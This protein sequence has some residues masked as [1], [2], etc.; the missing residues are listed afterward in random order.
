VYL[1]LE[2]WYF[3]GGPDGTLYASR[4]FYT[5]VEAEEEFRRV[6]YQKRIEASIGVRRD[7]CSVLRIV[8]GTMPKMYELVFDVNYNE[9]CLVASDMKLSEQDYDL[10]L[11]LYF[12]LEMLPQLFEYVDKEG[13]AFFK[14]RLR[15]G[16]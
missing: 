8:P 16:V 9:F 5:G 12:P 10:G 3:T 15:V 7:R 13:L 6:D 4:T 1:F 14:E 11:L 2:P